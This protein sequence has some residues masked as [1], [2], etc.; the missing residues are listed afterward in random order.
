MNRRFRLVVICLV[1]SLG[2]VF[3][4]SGINKTIQ[5]ERDYEGKVMDS[6]KSKIK[7]TISDTLLNFNIHF[8]YPTFY[9][10]YRDLYEFS[11][12]TTAPIR[13]S[14]KV[15]YPWLYTKLSIAYPLMPVAELYVAPRFGQKFSAVLSFAHKSLWNDALGDRMVND[16]GVHLAYRWKKGE[17]LIDAQ[18]LNNFYTYMNDS[19]KVADHT[20]DI[21][22]I[23]ALVRSKDPAPNSFYY[24]ISFRYS[25]LNDNQSRSTIDPLMKNEI[26]ADVSLGAT[27]KRVHKVFIRLA[28]DISVVENGAVGNRFLAGVLDICPTYRWEKGRWRLNLGVSVSSLYSQGYKNLD[29]KFVFAPEV[30]ATFEAVTSKLWLYAA[31]DGENSLIS[32]NRMFRYNPWMGSESDL[33]RMVSPF[34]VEAGIRGVLGERFAYNLM[35]GYRYYTHYTAYISNNGAQSAWIGENNSAFVA[36]EVRLNT[37]PFTMT[38]DLRYQYFSNSDYAL[39]TPS[40]QAGIVAEYNIRKRFFMEAS[41]Y[42]RNRTIAGFVNDDETVSYSTVKGFVDLGVKFSYSIN[43]GFTIFL[44]GKNLINSEIQ[45]FSNTYEPGVNIAAGLY[46]KL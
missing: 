32:F 33:G 35:G 7:T 16:A 6:D 43:P 46:F 44:D 24:D 41:C 15:K 5:V 22:A 13:P 2:E 19:V 38:A 4:Q 36:A 9:R 34:G 1:I 37:Q 29:K 27:L 26:L 30:N 28:N 3:A 8:D 23:N 11:P 42:F 21:F 39:M 18:F 10:P 17:A 45:Y 25:Y 14:G 31:V 40:F 12:V 20:F